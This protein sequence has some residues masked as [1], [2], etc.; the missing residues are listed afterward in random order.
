MTTFHHNNSRRE[1]FLVMVQK[2]RLTD[3]RAAVNIARRLRVKALADPNDPRYRGY[4]PKE[5]SHDNRP[6]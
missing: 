4:D 5:K 3:A 1:A 2:A 6:D